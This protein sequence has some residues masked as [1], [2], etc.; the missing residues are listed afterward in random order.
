MIAV[1]AG[2]VR[3]LQNP[4]ADSGVVLAGRIDVKSAQGNENVT[5]FQLHE[6]AII[7][8]SEEKNGWYRIVL[9]PDKTGWVPRESIGT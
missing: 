9:T 7:A 1:C 5:L 2:A 4:Y 8:I 6:G 3:L